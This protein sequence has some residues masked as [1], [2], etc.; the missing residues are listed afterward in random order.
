MRILIAK[1]IVFALIIFF[2]LP[3]FIPYKEEIML[4]NAP[5]AEVYAAINK[6]NMHKKNISTLILGDSVANQLYNVHEYNE[7]I[8]SLACNQA[9]S[10]AGHYILLKNFSD[11]NAMA[12]IN[13]YLIYHPNSFSNNLDD[14]W[15][16]DY[17]IKPFY[18]INNMSLFTDTLIR[19]VKNVPFYMLSSI[20][21]M[22]ITALS[23]KHDPDISYKIKTKING[24]AILKEN[25][26]FSEL[27]IEYLKKMAILANEKKFN[28]KIVSPFLRNEYCEYYNNSYIKELS[29]NGIHEILADYF[30]FT[31]RDAD[32]YID[33]AHYKNAKIYGYNPLNLQI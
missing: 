31:I 16:Y 15:T 21:L 25:E 33:H 27:S 4:A 19:Q 7:D 10:M 5:G 17:F 28:I 1:F 14:K 9:I 2:M 24:I 8:Y 30:A 12:G 18:N 3:Q 26:L 23:P 6:S 13:V 11:N 29:A 32:E 22:K 20:P